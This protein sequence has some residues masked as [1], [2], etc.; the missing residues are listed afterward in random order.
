MSYLTAV[1]LIVIST[2]AAGGATW[3]VGTVLTIDT[4][5][6]HHDVG[7]QVFQQV[8][9]MVSVLMAF[10]FSEVWGEYRTAAMAI[11]GECG[12]LHGGRRMLVA[13]AAGRGGAARRARDR[14]LR[15]QHR[16][17]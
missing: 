3:L 17:R 11:N 13:R 9:I 16:A 15:R 10:V 1:L 14:R 7:A 2:A 12:A 4:R 8:G 6:R 5:K